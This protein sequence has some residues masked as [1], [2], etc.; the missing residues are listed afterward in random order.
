M[1]SSDATEVEVLFCRL[2]RG[3]KCSAARVSFD[4]EFHDIHT[5]DG[6]ACKR[7]S[8]ALKGRESGSKSIGAVRLLSGRWLSSLSECKL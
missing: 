8:S 5:K 1:S 6:S 2:D 7:E 4:V 3:I